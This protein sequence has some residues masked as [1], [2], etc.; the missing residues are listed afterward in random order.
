MTA[1]SK[2]D[3]QI[4]SAAKAGI[5]E[6]SGRRIENGNL[7]HRKRQAISR[8]MKSHLEPEPI[9]EDKNKTTGK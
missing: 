8:N 3:I 9:Q 1:R 2:G 5:S 6:R 7:P 4:T